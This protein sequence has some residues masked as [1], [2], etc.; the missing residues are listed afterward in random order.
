MCVIKLFTVVSTSHTIFMSHTI[1]KSAF[2][3]VLLRPKKYI[4]VFQVSALK[5]LGMVSRHYYFIFSKILYGVYGNQVKITHLPVHLFF[6]FCFFF[7]K[8]MAGA[9]T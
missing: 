9:K 2:G 1:R 3:V 7:N 4:C 5:K 8:I 6:L